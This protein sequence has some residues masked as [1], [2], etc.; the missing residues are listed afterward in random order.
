MDI[1]DP[2][3][4]ITG[5]PIDG[6]TFYGPT[7]LEDSED[8]YREARTR[9]LEERGDE[10]WLAELQP[11]SDLDPI[12]G[13]R[14]GPVYPSDVQHT[15]LV[16]RVTQRGLGDGDLDELVHDAASRAASE[17]NNGGVEAQVAFLIARLGAAGARGLIDDLA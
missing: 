9:L 7:P 10:W 5:N 3:I 15:E 11:L 17:A 14:S 6:F 12:D 13:D 8:G 1:K 4:V 2:R 16:Q